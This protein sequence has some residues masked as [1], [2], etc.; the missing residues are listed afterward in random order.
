MSKIMRIRLMGLVMSVVFATVFT[1]EAILLSHSS[2]A[3]FAF[4]FALALP[5]LG[6]AAAIFMILWEGD[7]YD[8]PKD[9]KE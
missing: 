8:N 4:Y 2:I 5:A 3:I 9:K 1:M 7:S 6:T